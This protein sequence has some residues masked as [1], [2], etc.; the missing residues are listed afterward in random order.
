MSV[1]YMAQAEAIFR[2]LLDAGKALRSRS[3]PRCRNA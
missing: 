3:G 2:R 1:N